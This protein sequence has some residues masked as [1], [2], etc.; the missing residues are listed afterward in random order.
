MEFKL[1]DWIIEQRAKNVIRVKGLE[2]ER[3]ICKE[4]G[5]PCLFK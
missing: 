3:N 1:K 4:I 5:K 2:L